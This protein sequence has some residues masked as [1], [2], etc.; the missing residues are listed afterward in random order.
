MSKFPIVGNAL[1]H[2]GSGSTFLFHTDSHANIT[3][4]R[5]ASRPDQ[6]S[7]LT[8]AL[9]APSKNGDCFVVI[10]FAAVIANIC[11]YIFKEQR[12]S[13]PHQRDTGV[14]F[15]CAV[16]SANCTFHDFHLSSTHPA[17]IRVKSTPHY[18]AA[19]YK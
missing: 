11:G 16:M 10:D 15:M 9:P 2:M 12:G 6:H 18:N 5:T 14:T 19:P 3:L 7:A 13:V 4:P 1:K 17:I 8:P